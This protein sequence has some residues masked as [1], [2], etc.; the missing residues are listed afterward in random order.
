MIKQYKGALKL[1]YRDIKFIMPRYALKIEYDGTAFNGWQ[2]QAHLP[3]VQGVIN[4]ALINLNEDGTGIHGAGRTDAGV[5]ALGQIG[6][7]DLK[8]DWDIKS[9]INAVNHHVKPY[10]IAILNA[11]KVS[12]RFH[13]RF[14]AKKRY[15][16]YMLLVR[17]V[18]QVFNKSRFWVIKQTLDTDKMQNASQFLI[19]KHD[20][21]TF[22]SSLCQ[23]KSSIKTIDK[24][25]ITSNH[26]DIFHTEEEIISIKIEARSFLHNQ[27]RSIVGSLFKVGNGSWDASK[28]NQILELKDRK[29]CGP[30]APP[31]GL[32]LEQVDYEF[33]PFYK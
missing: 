18:P 31:Q 2:V 27:V 15:Y 4:K 17:H 25:E 1:N 12:D 26:R 5:H 8:K 28:I 33:N 21:Q 9:L 20:F 10:P 3:T 6:H 13:A 24:I 22:R 7:A 19:G 30:V 16:N 29:A 23:A 14:S 11:A 32:Y